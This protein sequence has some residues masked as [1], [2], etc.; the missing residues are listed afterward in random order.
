[1]LQLQKQ[2]AKLELDNDGYL[3][4]PAK[5]SRE[6]SE[7]IAREEGIE[8]SDIHWKAIKYIRDY[9]KE[10]HVFPIMDQVCRS[11][12]LERGCMKRL[13]GPSIKRVC[14]IAGLPQPTGSIP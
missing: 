4:D 10:Y 7:C 13:F 12:G 8:L 9:F 6:V 14:R 2:C 3:K 11:I 1:M 5:W